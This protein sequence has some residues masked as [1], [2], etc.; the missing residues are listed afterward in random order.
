MKI[1]IIDDDV[2]IALF[3]QKVLEIEGYRVTMAG[4]SNDGYLAYLDCNPDLVISDIQ[5][6]GKNGFELMKDIRMHHPKMKTIY[7]SGAITQFQS[8]LNE[9]KRRYHVD[10][11]PKPFA[12]NDLISLVS[13]NLGSE[14]TSQ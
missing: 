12:T 3:I 4:D 7:M 14:V 10:F 8:L 5:M 1:L 2:A 13:K 9:E 11:L 6:P